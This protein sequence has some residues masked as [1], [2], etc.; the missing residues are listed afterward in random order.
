MDS[1]EELPRGK[2]GDKPRAGTSGSNA[3]AHNEYEQTKIDTEAAVL[4]G[5]GFT[6][7]EIA[8]AQG[9]STQAASNRVRRAIARVPIE[10]V[11]QLRQTQLSR[12]D[13]QRRVA[14]RLLAMDAPLIQNGR[15]VMQEVTQEDGTKVDR[16]VINLDPK[17]R[18]LSEL[19][20]IED[21]ISTLTG[22][23]APRRIEVNVVTED[24]VDAE[25]KR[26]ERE[27]GAN[28]GPGG[29]T[30]SLAGASEAES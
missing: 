10:A 25:I 14:L 5:R 3:F 23:Q 8:E 22:T 17:F 7:A 18:A 4:R 21:S 16:P 28:R 19:R 20:K 24:A 27:L 9:C 11:T 1:D 2:W 13:F 15:V 29:E 30:P 26:L 12:Y 6:F